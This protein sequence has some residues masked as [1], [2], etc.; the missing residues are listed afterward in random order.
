MT[1]G[2]NLAQQLPMEDIMML[3]L[4]RC[5][6]WIENALMYSGGTHEFIDIVN[7]VLSG[8]MQLWAGERGCAVTEITVYPRKKILHVFLA[9]GDMEQILDFQESAAEFARIN[10]CDSMTIAGRRGWTR[11]LDKHDWEESFCVM[12]K[13]L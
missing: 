1:Y 8:T 5:R 6:Q 3:E 2:H 9:G 12:S 11:V 4:D 13:E 10:K 7:G